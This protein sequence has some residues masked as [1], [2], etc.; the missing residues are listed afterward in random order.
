[1]K[2]L[3]PPSTHQVRAAQGWFELGNHLE[4]TAELNAIPTT[5]RAH[6]DVLEVRLNIY[7]KEAKWE[8]CAHVAE[9]LSVLAP[10]RTCGWIPRSH[11]LHE[12]KRTDAAL[13]AL[14]P[15]V[16]RFPKVADIPYKL[17]CFN[18]AI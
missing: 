13:K 14:L 5:L 8:Q 16:S 1:M 12:M 6:P 2:P 18:C 4:A 3:E 10:E 7:A 15:A 17:A 11:A 9:A